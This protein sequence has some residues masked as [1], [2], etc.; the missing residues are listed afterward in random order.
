MNHSYYDLKNDKLTC[1]KKTFFFSP[2][3]YYLY[4]SNGSTN[5]LQNE[6]QTTLEWE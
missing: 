6:L 3:K 4:G 1:E 2:Q 5:T